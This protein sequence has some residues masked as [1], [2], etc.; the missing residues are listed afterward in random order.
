MLAFE[1]VD[2]GIGRSNATIGVIRTPLV[3][4]M[5]R[6]GTDAVRGTGQAAQ[7]GLQGVAIWP[8]DGANGVPVRLGIESPNPVP[9]Q[10][11]STLGTPA[12]LNVDRQQ[13]IEATSFVMT[14]A[15]TG[16]VVPTTMATSQNDLNQLMPHS[17]IGLVPL[18]P[19]E[20]DVS[21][22]VVFSGRATALP[23]G[24]TVDIHRDWTFTTGS[25]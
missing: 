22:R 15:A 19:L 16:V 25:H 9:S 10:D 18:V 3:M 24:S 5:T 13:T 11:V 14:N 12:T 17:F 21:Y 23:S 7:V 1:P 6:P 8:L 20:P 4:D 2:V